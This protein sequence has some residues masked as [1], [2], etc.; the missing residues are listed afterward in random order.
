MQILFGP[1]AACIARDLGKDIAQAA[2][3]IRLIRAHGKGHATGMAR[4]GIGILAN[5]DDA[6]LIRRSPGQR[7]KQ[8]ILCR[9][10]RAARNT[11]SDFAQGCQ[12][13]LVGGQSSAPGFG[14]LVHRV[15]YPGIVRDDALNQE[16]ARELIAETRRHGDTEEKMESAADEDHQMDDK[17]G[18]IGSRAKFLSSRRFFPPCLGASAVNSVFS[19]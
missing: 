12:R 13:L 17:H 6:N 18:M 16:N 2:R 11:V 15:P 19:V 9:Y 14:Y 8:K 5:D 4:R 10:G 3:Y 1:E 7:S